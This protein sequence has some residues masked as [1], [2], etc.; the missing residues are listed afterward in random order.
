MS[1]TPPPVEKGNTPELAPEP[2]PEPVGDAAEAAEARLKRLRMRSWRRGIKEMDLILGPY[3]DQCLHTLEADEVRLYD[4]LLSE[5]DQDLYAWVTGRASPPL[6][7][8]PMIARIAAH[9]GAR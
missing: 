6:A 8:A 3:A 2:A 7:H 5:N 1:G 4:A 9:A